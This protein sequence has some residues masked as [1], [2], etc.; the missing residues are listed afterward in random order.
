MKKYKVIFTQYYEYEVEAKNDNEAHDKAYEEFVSDMRY[1]VAH[2]IYDEVE[3]TCED[4]NDD[5]EEE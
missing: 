1:P 2:T 5:E 4:D 3:V